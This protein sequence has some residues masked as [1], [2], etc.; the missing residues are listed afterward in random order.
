MLLIDIVLLVEHYE[1]VL[2]QLELL[3]RRPLIKCMVVFIAVH[4]KAV[5][6]SRS[7]VILL[8]P[9]CAALCCSSASLRLGRNEGRRSIRGGIGRRPH[10]SLS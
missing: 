7:V 9:P 1:R 3:R 6:L 5:I 8:P 4:Y 10:E 2:G